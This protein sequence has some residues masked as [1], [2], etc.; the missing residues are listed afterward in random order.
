[1]SWTYRRPSDP[2]KRVRR[3]LPTLIWRKNVNLASSG[4]AVATN[5]ASLSIVKKLSSTAAGVAD[6]DAA[7]KQTHKPSATHT[8]V[9]S[10]AAGSDQLHQPSAT[11]PAVGEADAGSKQLHQP[12]GTVPAVGDNTAAPKQTHKPSATVEAVASNTAQISVGDAAN[13]TG[14]ITGVASDTATATQLHQP[15]TTITAVGT[16]DPAE[17]TVFVKL[18][19]T[20]NSVAANTAALTV[21]AGETNLT[22]TLQSVAVA[23]GSLELVYKLTGSH[24]AVVSAV[25]ALTQTSPTVT[26]TKG[27]NGVSDALAG[28][29]VLLDHQGLG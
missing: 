17:L 3:L 25:A 1:M 29:L 10:V 19:G 2:R 14:T 27:H 28:G 18:V 21:E 11:V 15:T 6:H 8:A 13:L 16:V 23:D 24:Q 7:S 9:G 20:V 26:P 5:T 22:A 4:S 12:A